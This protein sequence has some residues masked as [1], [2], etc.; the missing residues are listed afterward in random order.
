MVRRNMSAIEGKADVDQPLLTNL[1]F[2]SGSDDQ[3]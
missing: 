2:S 3:L 1:D